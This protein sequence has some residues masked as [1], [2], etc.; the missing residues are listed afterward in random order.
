MAGVVDGDPI[1]DG[2]DLDIDVAPDDGRV[3]AEDEAL[4]V[5]RGDGAVVTKDEQGG[6]THNFANSY[7]TP[8]ILLK[9][10]VIMMVD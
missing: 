2:I 5:F 3:V 10:M 7:K 1:T 9:T 6:D 8:S 4:G